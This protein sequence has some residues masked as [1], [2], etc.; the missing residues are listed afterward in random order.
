MLALRLRAAV[1]SGCVSCIVAC[2]I[3]CSVGGFQFFLFAS[4]IMPR[5]LHDSA[6]VAG[7]RPTGT[8]PRFS[9][10]VIVLRL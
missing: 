3:F 4:V 8:F 7:G 2:F 10:E 5:L 9:G 1:F 6:L